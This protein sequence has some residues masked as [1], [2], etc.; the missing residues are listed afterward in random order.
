MYKMEDTEGRN[1]S[2]REFG[3]GFPAA[4]VFLEVRVLRVESLPCRAP[5][6]ES[7][8]WCAVL[9]EADGDGVLLA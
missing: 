4:V 8:R 3:D 2:G 6:P 1:R 9:R 5:A 7:G